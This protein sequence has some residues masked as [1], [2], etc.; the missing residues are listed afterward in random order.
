MRQ[1]LPSL[2]ASITICLSLAA[3]GS[4]QNIL[5][6]ASSD[7]VPQGK[8]P[9]WMQDA[10]IY[11]I[12]PR[13]FSPE[14][15]LSAVT[16][17]LDRLQKLG[18]NVLWLMPISPGGKEK[19]LGRFGSPYSIRD[20]YAI[21]P[22]LGN[23]GDMQT[24]VNVAHQ[25]HM[26]VILDM[27]ADHT[28]WDSVMMAHPNFYQHDA[29]GRIVSPHGWSDVAGLDYDDRA[30]R[31]YMEDMFLYWL[32]EF[33]LDGF[34]CDAAALMPTSFWEELRPLIKRENP[35]ASLLA[36]ASNPELMQHAFDLDYAWPLLSTFD[37]V[38]GEGQPATAIR[39]TIETQELYFPAD[40]QHMLISDDHD[41]PRATVRY[42][43]RGSLAASSLVFT[44]PGVP[45]L[46]NGME[47]A[48][49]TESGAPELF[50]K[51]PVD[52]DAAAAFPQVPSFYKA[53]IALRHSSPA[54]RHGEL[55]WLHNSQ[56]E[57]VVTFLRRT[58][59]EDILVSINLSN[60]PFF[61]RVEVA[62]GP[63]QEVRLANAKHSEE[64]LPSL[65]LNGFETRIFRY[66][67]NP[68]R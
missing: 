38:I 54:L 19:R 12:F 36:E 6:P 2:C 25:R 44:L 35:E 59:E 21:D 23:K 51:H 10:V 41:A 29:A 27:V 33:H 45:L 57:H 52:W 62:P 18:V 60:Q 5:K 58:Q 61:G 4:A 3:S 66:A 46:F 32:K 30:L 31:R 40:A 53:L 50:D 43:V 48:D 63:W 24:L 64:A 42:G 37:K 14:G 22:A 11:E 1:S 34:R 16:S 8:Q 7:L 47:A 20:Y 65:S 17:Q 67:G 56:E 15:T 39:N 49:A 9:A 55:S 68:G 28:S 26:R 13:T